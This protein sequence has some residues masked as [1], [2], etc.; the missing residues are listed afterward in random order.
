VVN[1]VN[2]GNAS[3]AASRAA[4]LSA[5]D[6]LRKLVR[7]EIRAILCEELGYVL[8]RQPITPDAS[9]R[10]QVP[11]LPDAGG[12]GGRSPGS[13]GDGGGLGTVHQ[14]AAFLAVS[15]SWIYHKAA[16]GSIPCIRIGHSLR[17]D[18]DALRAWTRGERRGGRVVALK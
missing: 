18:M 4:D 6:M 7:E 14:A 9:S 1:Q 13:P 2:P 16:A 12:G 8:A 17:F 3:D 5:A 11:T 10:P 15:T